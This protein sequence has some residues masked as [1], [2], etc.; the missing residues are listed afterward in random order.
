VSR[1]RFFLHT[2]TSNAANPEEGRAG[3]AL[4]GSPRGRQTA[5]LA[6][7]AGELA[8]VIFDRERRI[9]RDGVDFRQFGC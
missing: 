4:L 1:T 9:A 6:I 5:P 8:I 2:N 7:S 3:A